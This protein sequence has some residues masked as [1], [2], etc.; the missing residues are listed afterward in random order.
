M[1]HSHPELALLPPPSPPP[2]F[3]ESQTQYDK[4]QLEI[5]SPQ[6]T[7]PEYSIQS[8]HIPTPTRTFETKYNGWK[9]KSITITEG[10]EAS[11][12]YDVDAS[13]TKL[14]FRSSDSTEI[15]RVLYHYFS[16]HIDTIII[17]N[18][19]TL[20]HKTNKLIRCQYSFDSVARPGSTLTWRCKNRRSELT[21]TD[22]DGRQLAKV[23]YQSVNYCKPGR[24]VILEPEMGKGDAMLEIVVSGMAIAHLILYMTLGSI[25]AAVS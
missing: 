8:D 14:M 20:K 6:D 22:Q 9:G 11:L 10:D 23:F 4:E 2:S 3:P 25:G 1:N 18:P 5:K 15:A 21:C 7:L 16:F 17:G 24:I 13:M 19:I 12:L